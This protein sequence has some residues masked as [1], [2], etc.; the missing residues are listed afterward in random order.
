MFGNQNGC[1][2]SAEQKPIRC[3]SLG[4][5]K[6][7]AIA[8]ISNNHRARQVSR[9]KILSQRVVKITNNA[10]D[11]LLRFLQANPK[12]QAAIDKI[13]N[14]D[15]LEPPDIARGPLLLGMSAAAKYLGVG[16]ST[17]WRMIQA[18]VLQKV[19]VLPGSYRVRRADLQAIA[20]GRNGSSHSHGDDELA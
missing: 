2:I 1:V 6:S 14:G 12:Q 13:L 4:I 20:D 9:L 7:V 15:V 3:T 10:N 18:G 8:A 19:E 16:R 17:L 11:R 5:W